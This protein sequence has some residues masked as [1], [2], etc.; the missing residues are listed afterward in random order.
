MPAAPT[1]AKKLLVAFVCLLVVVGCSGQARQPSEYGEINSK[2][3]G[4]F[5]NLMYGCTGVQP[6][7][8]KYI[9]ETLSSADYCECLFTGLKDTVPFAEVKKFEETQADAKAGDEITVPKGIAK[10][11]REC[12]KEA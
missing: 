8:G 3:E 4:Y 9:N 12:K 7:D 5:G 6:T 10:V 11:Q 2:G 1:A